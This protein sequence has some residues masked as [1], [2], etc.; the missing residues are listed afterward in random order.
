MAEVW[1]VRAAISEVLEQGAV[2]LAGMILQ[3]WVMGICC[4]SYHDFFEHQELGLKP[5]LEGEAAC[6]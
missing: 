2:C 1:E 5:A 6:P 4:K 3:D